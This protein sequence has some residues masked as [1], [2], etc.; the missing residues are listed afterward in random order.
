LNDMVMIERKENTQPNIQNGEQIRLGLKEKAMLL[1]G[2][3]STRYFHGTVRPMLYARCGGDAET[4][5]DVV[6]DVSRMSSRISSM[7]M[8]PFFKAPENLMIEVNG[9]RIPPF[10]TA[11]GM[12]KDGDALWA[13]TNIFGFQ[14]PGTVVLA[15]REGNKRVRVAPIEDSL[16]IIN[17]QG[18]P[19]KGL[20]YFVNN[21][22]RYRAKGGKAP[23][24]VSI[25]GL[26]LSAHNAI[27]TAM[28]EMR[29]LIE[30]LGPYVDGFVWDPFSPNTSALGLLRDPMVFRMTA[31]LM[32]DM[33]PGKLLLVKMGPYE[34]S[35]KSMALGLVGGFIRGGGQGVV[36]TNTKMLPKDQLPEEVR[37]VWGYPSAGRSGPFLKE[38]RLRSVMDIRTE[39]PDSII[40]GTGGILSAEDAF[41]TFCAGATMIE[42]YTPYAYFGPALV[43]EIIEG[44]SEMVVMKGM[45]TL[46]VLQQLSK[47]EARLG[48]L[49]QFMREVSD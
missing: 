30:R 9:K 41:A 31:E 43:K 48:S 26:P 19:S 40:V 39:F 14:E 27:A 5:H 3:F 22:S 25:C 38:Y 47:R 36:T 15:P 45:C 4:V 23:L 2:T 37:S 29:V 32:A 44:V 11:A 42:G 21:I 1:G 35:E 16:D 20:D 49:S 8:A 24:Y 17:A 34:P 10:G 18:F 12:D 7:I 46:E 6:L 33:S 13:F 28:N